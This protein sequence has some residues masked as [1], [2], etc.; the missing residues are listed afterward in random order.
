MTVDLIFV[1]LIAGYSYAAQD[2]QGELLAEPPA[3]TEQ[4]NTCYLEIPKVEKS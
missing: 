1:Y 4:T 3:M 2:F